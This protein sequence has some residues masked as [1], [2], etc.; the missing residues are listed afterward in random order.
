VCDA[1]CVTRDMWCVCVG[2]VRG[3]RCEVC[4]VMWCVM[5][6]VWCVMCDVWCDVWCDLMCDMRCVMCDVWCVMWCV[7]WFNVWYVMWDVWCVMCDVIWWA[8]CGVHYH[9]PPH[10]PILQPLQPLTSSEHV[11]VCVCAR[12]RD[13]AGQIE[14]THSSSHAHHTSRTTA[15]TASPS[16]MCFPSA[17][18]DTDGSYILTPLSDV[19][20]IWIDVSA[21]VCVCVRTYVC[22]CM[23][24][25][26]M[27]VC[28]SVCACVCTNFQIIPPFIWTRT[29]HCIDV[30]REAHLDWCDVMWCVMSYDVMWCDVMWCDV[31][32]CDAIWWHRCDAI[33]CA[34]MWSD[35]ICVW[36]VLGVS[37]I[38]L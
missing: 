15:N 13:K 30:F 8:I 10:P 2:S 16:S 3:V 24:C 19:P 33:W 12:A 11:C 26:V 36:Y 27:C 22:V 21:S 20:N 34:S 29:K 5:C 9:F 4:D 6:D 18:I 37:H 7:I 17:A 35:V 25:G 28:V 38:T 14:D 1:R 32:W 23:M 31:M